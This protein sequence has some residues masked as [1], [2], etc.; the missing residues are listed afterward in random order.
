MPVQDDLREREMVLLFN[1]EV[2]EDRGR[3]DVDA[4]LHLDELEEPLPFELKSTSK[5]SVSTV[6]DFGP[7][8]IAKW[9]DMHWL[10]AFYDSA[11]QKLLYCRYGS[12]AAMAPWIE[13]KE[14]YIRPDLVL[15][16]RAPQLVTSQ[17]LIAALGDQDTY[18]VDDAKLLMKAQWSAQQYR[19]NADL[20]DGRYSSER[21][22][23]LLQERCAYVIRRGATLNNPHISDSFLRTLPR[24]DREHAAMLRGRVRG[25]LEDRDEAQTRGEEIKAAMDPVVAS[26]A[27]AAATDEATE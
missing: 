20:L 17:D 19:D 7:Q 8:H 27:R 5:S 22:V 16:D 14:R 13:E 23:L 10:F 4:Y 15:A 11:G 3:A 1:L 6:R 21:M 18:S 26:Q 2:A 24:I 9:R 12:P 25:Y